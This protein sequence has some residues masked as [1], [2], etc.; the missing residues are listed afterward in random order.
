MITHEELERDLAKQAHAKACTPVMTE[1]AILPCPFCGSEC[2]VHGHGYVG[3]VACTK[4]GCSYSGPSVT[5]GHAE[6]I[7]LHNRI[8]KLRTPVNATPAAPDRSDR[9]WSVFNAAMT[10][11]CARPSEGDTTTRIAIAAAEIADAALAR[12]NR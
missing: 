1:Q 7:E 9:W 5:S 11:L 8:A 10:G 2:K 6:A 4:T 12:A 3:T